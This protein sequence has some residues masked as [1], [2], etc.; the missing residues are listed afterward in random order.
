MDQKLLLG[1]PLGYAGSAYETFQTVSQGGF[2]VNHHC[3]V[4]LRPSVRYPGAT[5]Q[6]ER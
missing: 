4:V 6:L 5:S 2:S 3:P 1:G